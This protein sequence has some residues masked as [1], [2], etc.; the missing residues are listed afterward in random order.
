MAGTA[1]TLSFSPDAS[2]QLGLV[3]DDLLLETHRIGDCRVSTTIT[4]VQFGRWHAND[5]D[6]T[7][8]E[9]CVIYF[10]FEFGQLNDE[11]IK[12]VQI[13]LS[14]YEED[15]NIVGAASSAGGGGLLG[16]WSRL[17]RNDNTG[18]LAR[19]ALPLKI[20]HR[21][22]DKWSG[23]RST[24]QVGDQAAAGVAIDV[25]GLQVGPS[26][27]AN[28]SRSVNYTQA[29]SASLTS[30]L[31]SP[32]VLIWTV[33]ENPINKTGIPHEFR[34]AVVLKTAGVDFSGR[35]EFKAWMGRGLQLTAK[36]DS[37]MKSEL[38]RR[39]DVVDEQEKMLLERMEA[40]E[41]SEELERKVGKPYESW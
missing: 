25:A 16:W 30:V 24:R 1:F 3:R 19:T 40:R 14:F 15:K 7:G 39:K 11:R 8:T 27:N 32:A 34:C 22:P 9:T 2:Q 10:K 21:E 35:V 41:F 31:D 29:N 28:I 36:K 18:L 4:D 20:M 37:F 17:A 13:K 5:G 6:R 26:V 12:R 23:Q 38:F 33:Q